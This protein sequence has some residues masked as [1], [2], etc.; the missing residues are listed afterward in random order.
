LKSAGALFVATYGL[1]MNEVIEQTEISPMVFTVNEAAQMLACS[2]SQIYALCKNG[3]LAHAKIGKAGIRISKA[4]LYA[5]VE[6]GGVEG[7]SAAS[8]A[9]KMRDAERKMGASSSAWLS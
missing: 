9:A 8:R 4:A 1:N 2:V 3:D 7:E 5:F 6:G